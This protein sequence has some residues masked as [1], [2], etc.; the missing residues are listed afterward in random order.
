[1]LDR[2]SAVLALGTQDV[3][4]DIYVGKT[5]EESVLAAKNDDAVCHLALSEGRNSH[6]LLRVRGAWVTLV[7]S[8]AE[9]WAF[10]S[11]TAVVKSLGG[12][13]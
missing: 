5:A 12:L 10:E 6:F 4:C 11:M 1:M 7:L 13:R 9:P 3:L 8:A 2:L